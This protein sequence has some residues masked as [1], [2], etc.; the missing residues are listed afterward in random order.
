[1][2]RLKESA[3]GEEPAKRDGAAIL[4][5]FGWETDAMGAVEAAR[6]IEPLAMLW[7]IPGFWE[8]RWTHAF[9]NLKQ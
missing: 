6:A 9:K 2:C 3:G 8:H 1:M 5:P 4:D 7:C